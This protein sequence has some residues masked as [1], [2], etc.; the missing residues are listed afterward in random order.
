MR[1]TL[2]AFL[3]ALLLVGALALS[4]CGQDETVTT[5]TRETTESAALGGS[6]S[7]VSSSGDTVST[8]TDGAPGSQETATTDEQM[9]S[10]W[11]RFTSEELAQFDGKDGRPAYVAVDGVVYDV[12]DSSIWPE[13]V[14]TVC[15]LGAMAGQDLSDV[16]AQAPARMRALME[17]MPVVGSLD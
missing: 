16:L 7:T 12:S 8:V 14:H 3:L 10:A 1:K 11:Q 15:N 13:G 9:T 6:T 5:N 17:E 4:A 2:V